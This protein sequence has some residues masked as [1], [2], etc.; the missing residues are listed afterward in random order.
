MFVIVGAIIVVVGV[1]GGYV[2]HHGNLSVLWQPTELLII[3]G[4][5]VG[6]FI[7]QS[8]PKILTIVF[9]GL[10]KVFAKSM[11]KNDFI[12]ILSLLNKIFSKMRK[13][14]LIAIENDI[15]GITANI[16]SFVTIP[17]AAT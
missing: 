2:L 17:K 13:E 6:A 8:P 10:T 7:S 16:S 5:A 9:K 3:G 4:A 1:V 11:S 12:D 15:I 14:G